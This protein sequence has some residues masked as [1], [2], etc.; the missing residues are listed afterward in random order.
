MKQN[1]TAREEKREDEKRPSVEYGFIS[2][3]KLVQLDDGT[4]SATCGLLLVANC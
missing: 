1:P 3:Q 4:N 2:L